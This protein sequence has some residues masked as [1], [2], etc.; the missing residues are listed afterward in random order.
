M[1]NADQSDQT[2]TPKKIASLSHLICPTHTGT[3]P[4]DRWELW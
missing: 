1:A 4:G 2:V 3:L